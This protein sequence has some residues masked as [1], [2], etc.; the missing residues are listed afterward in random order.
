MNIMDSVP[1]F[2]QRIRPLENQQTQATTTNIPRILSNRPPLLLDKVRGMFIGAFVGD[3]LGG[4]EEFRHS[5]TVYTGFT[6]HGMYRQTRFQGIRQTLPGQP[7]DD[8]EMTICLLRN[9]LT[10]AGTYN[11]TSTTIAYINWANTG[12]WAMG[13]NTRALFKGIKTDVPSRAMETYRRRLQKE[14]LDKPMNQ[15]SQSNGALMRAS[16]LALLSS[17]QPAITDAMI[18][19]PHPNVIETNLIY[20]IMLRWA[21]HGASGREIFDGI[22]PY[23]TQPDVMF[24]Y[25]Q[26]VNGIGR[27]L[28]EQ[29]GW[30]LHALYCVFLVITTFHDYSQAMNWIIGNNPGSDTDTNACIAGAVLGAILGFGTM[31]NEPATKFNIDT[32]INCD[33]AR[34]PSPRPAYFS[35]CDF[36][37]LTEAAWQMSSNQP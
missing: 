32:V 35:P 13:K 37:Q 27:P 21:L 15:R 34:S 6:D 36:N 17:N 3:A 20:V 1:D 23:I 7:T 4:P 8:T 10:D 22:K 14:A 19:N 31:Y 5:K 26:V 12:S 11:Q 25:E 16:P 30:C 9:L 29:R 2:I 33:V 28:T 18:S 24:V